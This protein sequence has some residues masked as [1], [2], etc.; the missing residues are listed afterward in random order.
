MRASL[1]S[2]LLALL[3]ATPAAAQRR[4][5]QDT[6]STS[7]PGAVTCGFCAA[8]RFGVVFTSL[9][10]PRRGLDPE[11]FPIEIE[12]VEIALAAADL[13]TGGCGATDR[14]GSVL[15]P[16][17][18]YAGTAEV[19]RAIVSLPL[20]EWP[21][22]TLVWEGEAPLELDVTDDEGRYSLTFNVLSLRDE[23][24][25]RVRVEAG[26][27][28]RV[29]LTVPDGA[30]GASPSCERAGYG[31]PGGFPFRDNAGE[32][33]ERPFA[34]SERRSF[35][36]ALGVG[37]VWNSEGEGLIPRIPGNW[38]IRMSAFT[39]GPGPMATDAGAGELDGGAPD[40]GLDAGLD[41][42]LAPDAGGGT[43]GGGCSCRT[44]PGRAPSGVVLGLTLALLATRRRPT[45]AS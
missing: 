6:L 14:G 38:G 12:S 28:L 13:T 7:T 19:P 15:V 33:P 45:R 16:I 35:I 25:E 26:T 18:V 20:E 22:E 32:D 21:G 4:L 34:G 8:E 3:L 30:L 27:Y 39:F 5:V 24:G 29:V 17:E 37:W 42:S 31:S 43:S 9:P 11:D 41:A 44:A 1:A 23:L 2:V 40:G 36:H 10:A